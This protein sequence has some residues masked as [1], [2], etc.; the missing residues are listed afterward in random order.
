MRGKYIQST[1]TTGRLTLPVAILITIA[2]WVIVYFLVPDVPKEDTTHSFWNLLETFPIPVWANKLASLL[3]YFGIGYLLIQMNNTFGLIQV[4]ASVQTSIYLLLIAAY[5]PLHQLCPG[6]IATLFF[7][8]AIHLL[9]NTYQRMRSSGYIFHAFLFVGLSSLV[10]P[11][12]TLL[13]PILLIGAFNFQGLNIRS[14][15]AA[16]IGWSFPYWFLLGHAYFYDKMELFYQPFTELATFY[17]IDFTVF[18]S[19]EIAMLGYSFVLFLVSSIHCFVQSYKDK[20]RTRIHLRFFI[21]LNVCIYILII[22]QPI[23][24]MNLLPLLL[25]GVSILTS[26][27]FVLTNSK[28]SNVFFVSTMI[29]LI[30]LFSYNLWMLL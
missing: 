7:V 11:Q 1:I 2:C 28:A 26:H 20:I 14:F 13:T 21:L 18:K 6:D 19:W 15:F 23:H 17:P 12:S 29:G 27:M 5:P 30:L 22:L 24:C 4:R 8:V 25:I 16:I 3:I 10:F 9:F